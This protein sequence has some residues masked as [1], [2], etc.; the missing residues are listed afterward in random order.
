MEKLHTSRLSA[1]AD[2]L[3]VDHEDGLTTAQLMVCMRC[4]IFF[5]HLPSQLI[6]ISSLRATVNPVSEKGLWTENRTAIARLTDFTSILSV[7]EQ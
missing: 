1:W 5:I 3:Q 7:N 6:S 2:R 4:L